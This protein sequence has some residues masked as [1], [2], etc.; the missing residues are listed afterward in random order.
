MPQAVSSKGP[1]MTAP[2]LVAITFAGDSLQASV[3]TFVSQLVAAT[4]YWSGATS[5]YGVGPLTAAS[6]VH[7][8]DMPAAMLADSDVRTWL[9]Q[10]I[11]GGAGFPQPDGNTIYALFYPQGTNVTEGGGVTCQQLN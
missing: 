10:K 4:S 9:T 5:Q 8:T 11:Q 6:P 2:K 3:D 1:V 7:S